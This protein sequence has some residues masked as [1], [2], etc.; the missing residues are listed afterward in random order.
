[1]TPSALHK[2]V[3]YAEIVPVL[4]ESIKAQQIQIEGL[5]AETEELRA[6]L[7]AKD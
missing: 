6:A 3:A 2:A 1:V 4:V 7:A 5:Q